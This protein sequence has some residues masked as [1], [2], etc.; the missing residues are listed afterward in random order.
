MPPQPARS[1]LPCYPDLSRDL[2]PLGR[3]LAWLRAA[4]AF[5]SS[6]IHEGHLRS[7]PGASTVACPPLAAAPRKPR[8]APVPCR[9][10]RKPR[11]PP[12]RGAGGRAAKW[13]R[14]Q[15]GGR[16]SGLRPALGAG[17]AAALRAGARGRP[18]SVAPGCGRRH[19][20]GAVTFSRA[21]QNGARAFPLSRFTPRESPPEAS[22]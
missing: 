18:S 9:A 10:L 8:T 16:R 2:S 6:P 19:R 1:Y 7:A 17:E 14:G 4:G 15:R 11:T 12:L 13:P 22:R 3:A 5:C 21:P 20:R